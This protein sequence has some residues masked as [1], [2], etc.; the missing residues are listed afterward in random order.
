MS[1]IGA[2]GEEV[3]DGFRP[4]KTRPKGWLA[5]AIADGFVRDPNAPDP[6][7]GKVYTGTVVEVPVGT[8]SG[9][10]EEE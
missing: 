5:D 4:R 7:E 1:S 6:D 8:M 3:E 10:S 9:Q 2:N